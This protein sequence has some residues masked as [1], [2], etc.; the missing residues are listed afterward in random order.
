MVDVKSIANNSR[1]S[2]PHQL[3]VAREYPG[4]SLSCEITQGS[5]TS[6]PFCFLSLM[7]I[8]F[9]ISDEND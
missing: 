5:I 3:A 1:T 6:D 2:G 4:L 9:K 8:L 7:R